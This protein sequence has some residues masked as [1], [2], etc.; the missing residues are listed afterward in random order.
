[1]VIDETDKNLISFVNIRRYHNVLIKTTKSNVN[2]NR[3][4]EAKH[5][6]N[7]LF[8]ISNELLGRNQNRIITI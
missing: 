1:M 7:I 8:K 3:I 5:D 2:L 6:Q 4:I